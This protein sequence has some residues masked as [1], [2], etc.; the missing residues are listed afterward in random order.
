MTDTQHTWTAPT[1]PCAVFND[2]PVLAAQEAATLFA[3]VALAGYPITADELV[4]AT[5]IQRDALV[6]GLAQLIRMGWVSYADDD[7]RETRY[8]ATGK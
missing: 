5:G 4:P 6:G 1:G 7:E 3:E 2:S 8:I